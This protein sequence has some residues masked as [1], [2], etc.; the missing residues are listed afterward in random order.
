LCQEDLCGEIVD[1]TFFMTVTGGAP[2]SVTRHIDCEVP[3]GTPLL[4][5]PGGAIVW[6]PTEGKSYNDLFKT[7]LEDYLAG[8][9]LKSVQG[10]ARREGARRRSS[11]DR[12]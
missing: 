12:P 6:A 5:T 3:E 1:G 7:L 4:V 8:V 10:Q 9:L 2:E 11:D